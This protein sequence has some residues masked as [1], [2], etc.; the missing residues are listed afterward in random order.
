MAG[1]QLQ[2]YIFSRLQESKVQ[3]LNP[4]QILPYI[5]TSLAFWYFLIYV[6]YVLV[7]LARFDLLRRE[8]PARCHIM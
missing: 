5:R 1:V 6:V 2:I 8:G 4:P 7:Y 3:K